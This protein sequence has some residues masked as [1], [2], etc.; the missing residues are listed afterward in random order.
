MKITAGGRAG[1]VTKTLRKGSKVEIHM[2]EL[3][4]PRWDVSAWKHFVWGDPWDMFIKHYLEIRYFFWWPTFQL[5]TGLIP[6]WPH[7]NL[8][9]PCTSVDRR[10]AGKFSDSLSTGA[11]WR[12]V[13]NMHRQMT[14]T[15][16]LFETGYRDGVSDYEQLPCTVFSRV[17]DG[18][19]LR[20]IYQ[21]S[22]RV[23]T[24][25]WIK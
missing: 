12:G 14:R 2:K 21:V 10:P 24:Y 6:R 5:K 17:S 18:K 15:L 8:N 20:L 3:D 23:G 16:F 7:I 11:S 19:Q 22:K 1:Q 9:P 13:C 4:Q 25:A